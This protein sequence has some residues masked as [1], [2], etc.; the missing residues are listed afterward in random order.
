MNYYSI[1]KAMAAML[2][3]LM[4]FGAA[5][6]ASLAGAELSSLSFTSVR[7]SAA[8]ITS[9]DGMYQYEGAAITKVL[10]PES[11][12]E[13]YTIPSEIDGVLIRQ[14]GPEAFKKCTA[15]K[16][17]TIPDSIVSIKSAAFR[18]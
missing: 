4:I 3:G 5:P 18:N 17:L 15:I 1:K 16:E 7:A 12:P 2:A 13:N 14:I 6:A 10:K 9:A 8:G 11:L